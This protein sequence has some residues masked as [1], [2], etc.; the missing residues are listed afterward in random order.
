MPRPKR[1]EVDKE[2]RRISEMARRV[3]LRRGVRNERGKKKT[4]RARCKI[5]RSVRKK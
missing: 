3:R 4:K 2:G 5:M 1:R